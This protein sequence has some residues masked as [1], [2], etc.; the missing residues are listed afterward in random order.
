MKNPPTNIL[1]NYSNERTIATNSLITGLPWC[2]ATEIKESEVLEISFN[3]ELFASIIIFLL[4]SLIGF[5]ITIRKKIEL[6]EKEKIKKISKIENFFIK[7]K[8]RYVV[9]FS[10]IFTIGYFIFITSFFQGWKKAAFYNDIPD[11][12]MIMIL[13][14]LF[15]YTFKLKNDIAKK[16]IQW[17]SVLIIIDKLIQV[18]FEEYNNNFEI[19]PLYFWLPVGMVGF[20]GLFLIFYGFKKEMKL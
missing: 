2:L 8:I 13:I 11:L 9:L 6:M 4:F 18:F 5:L 1:I 16:L 12:V 15:F 10:L 17:G 14:N 3:K 20:V 19:L 7:L